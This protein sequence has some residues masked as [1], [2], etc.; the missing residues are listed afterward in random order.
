MLI[1][2]IQKSLV[3]SLNTTENLNETDIEVYN[4]TFQNGSDFD[5]G[6]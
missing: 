6:F 4:S 2:W 1:C 3:K 5:W